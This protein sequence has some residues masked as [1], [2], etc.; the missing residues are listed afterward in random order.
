MTDITV[1]IVNWNTGPLLEQ[2][3]ASL[4]KNRGRLSLQVIVVDN[5]SGDQSARQAQQK[6]PWADFIYSPENR[7][8]SSGNNLALARARGKHFLM[9]NPD[10]E[11][12]AGALQILKDFLDSHPGAAAAGPRLEYG[13][14]SLQRS[15]A[16]RLVSPRTILAETLGWKWLGVDPLGRCVP[17]GDTEVKGLM[18]ACIMLRK[19]AVD[20]VGLMDE[21]FFLVYEEADWCHRLIGAGWSLWYLPGAKVTHYTGQSSQHIPGK[22]LVES[23]QSLKYYLSKHYGRSAFWA[24]S[25]ALVC[26]YSWWSLKTAVKKMIFGYSPELESRKVRFSY[27]LQGLLTSRR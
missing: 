18:G 23:Y 15:W 1:A 19:E 24:T 17:E 16:G 21:N 3:L 14:G 20:Q 8:F 22:G 2:C 10:T 26:I 13:D 5:N 25:L 9:L 11:V 12:R 6:H 4:Q 27:I 7:G